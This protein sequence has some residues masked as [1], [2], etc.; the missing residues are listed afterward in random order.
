MS[1]MLN[2][3]L[4]LAIFITFSNAQCTTG[5]RFA[6][7][8]CSTISVCSYGGI[9]VDAFRCD[10]VNASLPF[11]SGNTG[12]CKSAPEGSCIQPSELCPR[13]SDTFPSECWI[14]PDHPKPP[15]GNASSRSL[16]L[17]AVHPL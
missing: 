3:V 13:A 8:N 11:C 16:Q 6:C 14:I 9:Q 5:S 12:V 17:L 4:I 1:S 7:A 15:Q 10:S 2:T